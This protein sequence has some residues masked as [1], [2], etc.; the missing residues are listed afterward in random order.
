MN[1]LLDTHVF[2][3]ARVEGAQIGP[4]T[5]EIL[6]DPK[7][8][9][10]LSAVVSW[11]ISIKWRLGKLKLPDR[12]SNLVRLSLEQNSL[13][14][15]SVTH[16]H[17]LQVGDLPD[18]HHDPFDR[19]LVAQAVV[20]NLILITADPQLKAYPARIHWARD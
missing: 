6:G 9:I 3:W 8:R 12:P 11:E 2:L 10:Y 17:S 14:S 19:L 16:D 5:W 4:R 15:L 13:R 7:Q 18:H 20:E 1:Y